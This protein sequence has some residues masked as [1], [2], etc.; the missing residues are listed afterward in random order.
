[1]G[2]ILAYLK[3]GLPWAAIASAAV[4]SAPAQGVGPRS[5]QP[6]LF[7]SPDSGDGGATNL[8][9]LT[10]KPPGA[11]DLESLA[12]APEDF[13]FNPLGDSAPL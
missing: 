11:L 5:G 8:P 12:T 10:P 13:R 1:M 6:I 2:F 3:R 7:S 4:L 9:S